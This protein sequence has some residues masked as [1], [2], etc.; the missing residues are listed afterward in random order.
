M[1]AQCVIFFF[2]YRVYIQ[3]VHSKVIWVLIEAVENLLERHLLAS[4]VQHHAVCVSFIC[5]LDE[6]QQVFLGHAGSCVNVRVHL[7]GMS[8]M[9]SP[10]GKVRTFKVRTWLFSSFLSFSF[11]FLQTDN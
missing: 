10:L 1:R 2:S 4:L 5:F 3:R 6:G 11:F 9:L 7:R 8:N